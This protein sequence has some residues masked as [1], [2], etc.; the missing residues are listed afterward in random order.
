MLIYSQKICN[1]LQANF[2]FH[3]F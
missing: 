1:S 2:R 3:T